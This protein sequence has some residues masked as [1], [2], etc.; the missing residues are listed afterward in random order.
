MST[1]LFKL[2]GNALNSA[3]PAAGATESATLVRSTASARTPGSLVDGANP[4]T[5]SYACKGFVSN[6]KHTQVGD[7]LVEATDRVVQI[8]GASL[9]VTPKKGDRVT[10]DGKTQ[11]VV[12]FDG[13]PALWTLLCRS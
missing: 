7:T 12:D 5:T 11:P 9:A 1:P 8:L 3:L 2:V 13:N 4:T 10:I 6:E